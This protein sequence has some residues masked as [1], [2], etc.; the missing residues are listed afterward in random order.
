MSLQKLLILLNLKNFF[1]VRTIT[2]KKRMRKSLLFEKLKPPTTLTSIQNSNKNATK[3]LPREPNY[4]SITTPNFSF[5]VATKK[6]TWKKGKMI[7]LTKRKRKKNRKCHTDLPHFTLSQNKFCF[8]FV[9]P[10]T[11]HLNSLNSLV[12]T[13]R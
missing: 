8:F 5:S 3:L 1:F 7:W 12:S 4:I 2:T 13:I 11:K 9:A 6:I 10:L